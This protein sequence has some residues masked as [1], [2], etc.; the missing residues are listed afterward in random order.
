MAFDCDG[1]KACLPTRR[2]GRPVKVR[3]CSS[4]IDIDFV[5]GFCVFSY[6]VGC[7][8]VAAEICSEPCL[9]AFVQGGPLPMQARGETLSFWS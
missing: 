7:A 5:E 1:T 9:T 4:L 8:I 6:A 3:K 2:D